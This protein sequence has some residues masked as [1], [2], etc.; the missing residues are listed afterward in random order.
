MRIRN[1]VYQS[2]SEKSIYIYIYI[3]TFES[4]LLNREISK[5]CQLLFAK[6]NVLEISLSTQIQ[7]LNTMHL[8]PHCCFIG[9][10]DPTSDILF[11]ICSDLVIFSAK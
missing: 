2:F 6:F 9:K 7:E 10:L 3:A 4:L 8:N 11:S 1:L 5:T